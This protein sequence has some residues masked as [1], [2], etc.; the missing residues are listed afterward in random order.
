VDMGGSVIV[1]IDSHAQAIEA[2]NS[3]HR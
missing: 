3:W 1:Q 2:K